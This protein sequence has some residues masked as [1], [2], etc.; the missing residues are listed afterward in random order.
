MKSY[1]R[2]AGSVWYFKVGP[3]GFSL[4]ESVVGRDSPL[5]VRRA[6]VVVPR[7]N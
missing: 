6:H 2:P 4:R 7:A 3:Y 5:V 1:M